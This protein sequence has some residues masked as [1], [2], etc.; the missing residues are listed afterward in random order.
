M[1]SS[2]DIFSFFNDSLSSFFKFDDYYEN[3]KNYTLHRIILYKCYIINY[4]YYLFHLYKRNSENYFDVQDIL[5]QLANK[6]VLFLFYDGY[7]TF[8]HKLFFTSI[9]IIIIEQT[10]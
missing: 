7:I 9:A 8:E 2:I 1:D 6:Y 5:Y 10:F 4:I 3:V